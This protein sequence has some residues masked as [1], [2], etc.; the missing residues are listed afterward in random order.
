[1]ADTGKRVDPIPAFR[2][3]VRF[4]NVPPG[5][6]SDC[7]GL[8]IETEVQ[9]YHEGGVNTHTWKFVTRSKQQNVVLKRG[10]VDR[11]MWSWYQSIARGDMQFRNGTISVQDPSGSDEVI[12]FQLVQAF[13]V[14]WVMA[15]LSA[16]QNN[17]AVETVEFAH[18]GFERTK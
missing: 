8:Q 7:S 6:F 11:V 5:G 18:Q 3:T 16:S 13:P 15:D 1:M 12:E 2:F 4:D 9:D 17:L 14:K 10:I